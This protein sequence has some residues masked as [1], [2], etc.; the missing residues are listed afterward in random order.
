MR[1]RGAHSGRFRQ[2][3]FSLLE[4]LI[5]IAILA[6]LTGLVLPAVHGWIAQARFDETARQLPGVFATARADTRGD[7]IARRIVA[8]RTAAGG[9]VITAEKITPRAAEGD[10]ARAGGQ[11]ATGPRPVVLI[12]LPAGCEVRTASEAMEVAP[13]VGASDGLGAVPIVVYL[14]DGGAVAAARTVLLGPGG[15]KT[16]LRFDRL[17]GR[18]HL[19]SDGRSAAAADAPETATPMETP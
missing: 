1:D 7:G 19:G 3:G 4:L 2:R 9:C 5:A 16:P 10:A 17:T 11:E 15:R 13:S 6:G 18:L 8:A 14:P 12:E